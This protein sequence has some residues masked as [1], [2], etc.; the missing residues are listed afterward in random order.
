LSQGLFINYS[1]ENKFLMLRFFDAL[2]KSFLNRILNSKKLKDDNTGRPLYIGS[3]M[4]MEGIKP[5]V[6]FC[7]T[8]CTG[9][10][11]CSC[12]SSFIVLL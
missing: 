1:G 10:A 5:T 8:V 4:L 7:T 12:M 9:S 6:W 2:W 11:T 3:F